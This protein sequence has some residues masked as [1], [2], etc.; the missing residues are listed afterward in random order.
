M[1]KK[2]LE[3]NG[4]RLLIRSHECKYEGYEFTHEGRVLTIFSA[5]NYYETGSNRA[6]T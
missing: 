2:Y 5:S 1:T 4:F 3:K 6:P